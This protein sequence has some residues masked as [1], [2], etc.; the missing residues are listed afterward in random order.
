LLKSEG[1]KKYFFNT[2]WLFFEQVVRLSVSFFVSIY[3]A[4]YLGP[5]QFGL[6]NYSIGFVA[7]F[8]AISALGMEQIVI[9]ELIKNDRKKDLLLGTAFWL[10]AAGAFLVLVLLTIGVHFTSNDSFTNLLIFI[11]AVGTLFQAINVVDFYFQAQVQSKFTVIIRFWS[12][13][14]IAAL[15]IYLMSVEA[16]LVWFAVLILLENILLAFGYILV[17][18]LRGNYILSWVFDFEIAKSLIQSSWPLMFSSIFVSV[19][20]KIDQVMLKEMMN[21]Q[22]VGLYSS[23]VILSEAWYF[24]PV[25]IVGSFFPAIVESKKISDKLYEERLELLYGIVVWIAIFIAIPITFLGDWIITLIYG[26]EYAGAASVLKIHIWAAV[27]VF[28]GVANSQWLIIE[29][30]MQFSFYRTFIGAISN[31]ALNALLIPIL[32]I[33]GAA[34]ATVISYAIASYLSLIFVKPLRRNLWL[35]TNSINPF[36]TYRKLRVFMER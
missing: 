34:I 5:E 14:G 8:T 15:K 9:R 31:I 6:L 20:M 4:R 33:E 23:A 32:G 17:Y 24:V 35:S 36:R 11:I 22:A 25:V 19:Y 13:I 28:L 10:K 3:V 26:I 18:K 21:T 1:F 12:T 27:F 16:S 30:Y 29:N 2:S 7:L